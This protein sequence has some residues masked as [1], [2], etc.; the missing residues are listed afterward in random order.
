MIESEFTRKVNEI[1]TKE[2]GVYCEKMHNPMRGGTPD[3][4]YSRKGLPDIWVEFKY[5]K[6]LSLRGRAV[7]CSE[8]Q[9]RWLKA[10]HEEGRNVY[11]LVGTPKNVALFSVAELLSTN[12]M[13]QLHHFERSHS[14]SRLAANKIARLLGCSVH[15]SD[16]NQ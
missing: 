11:V 6:T 10:R 1:L 16:E 7:G 14:A 15:I 8:L 5:H 13:C 12:W 3:C 4:W 2:Y 9:K